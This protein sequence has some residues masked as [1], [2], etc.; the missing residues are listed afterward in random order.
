ME[1]RMSLSGAAELWLDRILV[2]TYPVTNPLT[3][4]WVVPLTPGETST[5]IAKFSDNAGNVSADVRATIAYSA[6]YS[7][8]VPLIVR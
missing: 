3:T 6:P 1:F 5:V 4:T 2:A 7:I 8:F